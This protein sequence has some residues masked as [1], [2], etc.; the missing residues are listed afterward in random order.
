MAQLVEAML[1]KPESRG[2][3]PREQHYGRGGD[4]AS[5]INEY[6]VCFLRD[7]CGRCLGLT[8]L[9]SSRADSRNTGCL[10]LVEPYGPA[11]ASAGLA[12]SFRFN[13]SDDE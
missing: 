7:K 8:S 10:S 13:T 2:L 9:S 1:Y 11:H 4:S 3:I 5:M 6:Q 12:L